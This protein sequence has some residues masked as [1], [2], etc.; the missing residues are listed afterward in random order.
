MSH[1]IGILIQQKI[2]VSGHDPG[3]GGYFDD[4][5]D[6]PP[7]L[8]LGPV[9]VRHTGVGDLTYV[10]SIPAAAAGQFTLYGTNNTSIYFGQMPADPEEV[11]VSYHVAS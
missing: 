7:D 3:L 1:R 10:A 6:Y 8:T 4:V 11:Y 2:D 9:F 5:L